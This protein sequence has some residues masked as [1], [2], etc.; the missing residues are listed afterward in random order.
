MESMPGNDLSIERIVQSGYLTR[1]E[2]L[3]L[4]ALAGAGMLVGCAVNPVTGERQFNFVSPEQELAIDKQYA[5]G[6]ISQDYGKVQD[7][8]LQN[9]VS[10]VGKKIGAVSH[11]PGLPYTFNVV[12]ANYDNA[13]AFPG[14]TICATRGILLSIGSEAELAALLGHE[15]G[16]VNARH[17]AQQMSKQTVAGIALLGLDILFA[18]NQVNSTL[19]NSVLGLGGD[20]AGLVLAK[21]SRTDE[22]QADALG[23]EYMCRAGYSPQGMINLMDMLRS[24]SK[25][26]PTMI[27]QMFSSHPMSAE[28]YNTMAHEARTKYARYM[29]AAMNRE[30]YMDAT[31]GLRKLKPAIDLQKEGETA[32]MEGKYTAG[33]ALL[34]NALK[35]APD[36]YTGLLLMAKTK[37]RQKSYR[38]SIPYLDRAIAAYPGEPQAKRYRDAVRA[39]LGK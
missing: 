23:M 14:G 4:L 27:E 20:A 29:G 32:L 30:R 18:A 25:R 28:R 8:S 1:R 10:G 19:A 3:A 35:L 34:G 39:E 2:V 38:E 21:Y 37:I 15:A 11:R 17:T 22:R 16:H 31:A 7:P 24:L 5:P 26:E 9:Y 6:Q 13:Y 36:D 33:E 12:S